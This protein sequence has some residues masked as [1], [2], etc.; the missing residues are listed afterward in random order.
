MRAKCYVQCISE[1]NVDFRKDILNVDV[2]KGTICSLSLFLKPCEQESSLPIFRAN[3]TA[4]SKSEQA[5]QTLGSAK[6]R[7][8]TPANEHQSAARKPWTSPAS[9]IPHAKQHSRSSC[10]KGNKR[11]GPDCV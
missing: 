5:L 1:G 4:E 6:Q 8:K 11:V 3:A 2:A 10:Q 9:H 7:R